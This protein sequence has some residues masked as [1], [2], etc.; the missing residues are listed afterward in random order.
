MDGRDSWFKCIQWKEASESLYALWTKQRTYHISNSITHYNYFTIAGCH[1]QAIHLM[2]LNDMYI[3]QSTVS[4]RTA[5]THTNG[6]KTNG[7][8]FIYLLHQQIAQYHCYY[9]YFAF[10][11]AKRTFKT[12]V[13]LSCGHRPFFNHCSLSRWRRSYFQNCRFVS[14]LSINVFILIVFFSLLRV[15]YLVYKF[16]VSLI[17]TIL[18]TTCSIDD[19]AHFTMA[20]WKVVWKMW[21]K[22]TPQPTTTTTERIENKNK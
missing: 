12:V 6:K 9:D 19:N 10:S 7:R 13:F 20:K 17:R 4:A 11:L 18:S 5:H 14:L 1:I 22:I 3:V 21:T 16:Y 8:I 2:L 15:A